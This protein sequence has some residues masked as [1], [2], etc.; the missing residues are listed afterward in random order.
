MREMARPA[1]SR[2]DAWRRSQNLTYKQLAQGY[3]VSEQQAYVHCRPPGS[4]LH[5]V[6]RPAL[7]RRIYVFTA[8]AVTPN[9]FYDLPPLPAQEAAA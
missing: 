2:F 4:R 1:P 9:D 7:M 6:P 8:A 5:K 3:G